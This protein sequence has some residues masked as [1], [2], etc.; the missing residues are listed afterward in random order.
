MYKLSRAA[1]YGGYA[2]DP[3]LFSFVKKAVKGVARIAGG[4]LG[5][6]G[7]GGGGAAP[8]VHCPPA[9][10]TA[11]S[12]TDPYQGLM[13]IMMM[14]NF[15]GPS[16]GGRRRSRRSPWN[17]YMGDP[18]LFDWVKAQVSGGGLQRVGGMAADWVKAHPALA[19]TLAGTAGGLVGSAIGPGVG[20]IVG[21]TA[22]G[23]YGGMGPNGRRRYRRMNVCN[24]RALK[25]AIRRTHGFAKIAR[26]A[27][28][29]TKTFKA[30]PKFGRKR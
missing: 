30:K 14:Q 8:V 25:R 4:A 23:F 16:R 12:S 28:R 19:A 15:M 22:R 24:P 29:S 27:L 9:A 5:L 2:G 6:G 20:R 13:Q 1:M 10:A 18:G 26:A 17:P 3:G 11:A 21:G 7:G